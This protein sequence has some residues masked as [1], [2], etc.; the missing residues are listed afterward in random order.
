MNKLSPRLQRR[1]TVSGASTE[2]PFKCVIFFV[3]PYSGY[4]FFP[5]TKIWKTKL[6]HKKKKIHHISISSQGLSFKLEDNNLLPL[7]QNG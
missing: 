7:T 3:N 5:E 6:Q 4:D 2:S 1:D